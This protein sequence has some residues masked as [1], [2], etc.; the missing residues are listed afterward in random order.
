MEDLLAKVQEWFALYGLKVAGAVVIVV[1]GRWAAKMLERVVER[2]MTRAK[3]E[4]TLVS[5]VSHLTYITLIVFVLIAALKQVGFETT[6]FIAVVGAAGL[7]VGL[8]LQGSLANFASGVLLTIF[9]P[10]KV[11]DFVEVAG[12]QGTVEDVDIFTTTV[13]TPD[14]RTVIVPNAK[15]LS[16]NVSSRVRIR[17]SSAQRADSAADSG[18]LR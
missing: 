15:K 10:L 17:H 6:S 13:V 11:G 5:F 9:R 18:L 12:V 8:A 1:V 7:A 4:A 14:N 2:V 3:I 16:Q